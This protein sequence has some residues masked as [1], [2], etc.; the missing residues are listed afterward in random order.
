[1][2]DKPTSSGPKTPEITAEAPKAVDAKAF[3]AEAFSLN[4]TRLME[5]GSKA[6]ALW[7]QSKN[8]SRDGDASSRNPDEASDV[9]KTLTAV[10]EYWL[11][12][13]ARAL[14]LQNRLGHAYLELWSHTAHRL[15][16]ETT[17]PVAQPD[18]RDKRFKD[19][20]WTDNPFFDFVKQAYLLT[21]H[22]ADELVRDADGLDPHIKHKAEF[23]IRQI[24]NA[25][26]PSNFVLTNPE[27]LR[28]TLTSSGENLVRGMKMLNE[29]VAA[30]HGTLRIRQTDMERLKVGRDLA[31]TP[32]KVVY[33]NELI[34]LI[35]YAP[36]TPSVLRT[37]VLIVPPWINKYY[38]LDLTPQKS[39]I[40]WAVDQGLTVFAISWVNPDERHAGKTFEDYMKR[41]VIAAM[42]AIEKITGEKKV[43]AVGY[44]VGGTMLASTL[45]WL[46]AKRQV[47]VTSATFLATQVDFSFAGDL[48]VFVDEAQVAALERLMD[49]TGY[50]DGSKM[51]AVF[52]MLRANELIWPYV[53][54]N[55]MKGQP[56]SAFDLL[57]WNSDATRMTPANHS[58]YLRNCY[59][60]NRLS[61]GEMALDNIRLDLRKVTLPVYNL[62][63]REDHIAPAQSVFYG[64][65]FFGGPV[66][67]VLS[68]SGHIAGVINP[69]AAEKY[70]FWTNDRDARTVDD[71]LEGAT[72]HKGSWWPDWANWLRGLDAEETPARSPEAGPVEPI[73]DAPGSYVMV[74]S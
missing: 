46:A 9:I 38:I 7:L 26:A 33:Q 25:V 36:S 20:E 53:I 13:P 51:A 69:P 30:G 62:A 8:G 22:W 10:M 39:F 34:Q 28:E 50:L 23:Y 37:P 5:Q 47:R 49:A 74:R 19:P 14:E 72:E 1:M 68:G 67:F 15:A 63:T 12:D 24:A 66:R 54:N 48:K 35:Q 45:A 31:I 44:C 70:Q 40:K 73:E 58:F 2:D 57:F 55:Y 41:G 42:D 21:S 71:W 11:S 60:E 43:H 4:L 27:L 65:K 52:N 16:G 6:L 61:K 17:A 3:D 32:G 56:P 29:D 64:T 18:P 59:L